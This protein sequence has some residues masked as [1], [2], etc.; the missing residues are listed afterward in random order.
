M[1]LQGKGTII[2]YPVTCSLIGS[3]FRCNMKGLDGA[4]E[5]VARDVTKGAATIAADKWSAFTGFPI[6]VLPEEPKSF[7][8]GVG[9][10]FDVGPTMPKGRGQW[11]IVAQGY[12]EAQD[13]ADTAGLS[14][15]PIASQPFASLPKH[16]VL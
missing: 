5:L 10:G 8:L 7:W 4:V 1:S 9:A 6:T 16:G 3:V 12:Q 14:S 13:K 15:Y 2:V 11:E